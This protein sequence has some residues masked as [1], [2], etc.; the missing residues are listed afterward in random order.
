[1]QIQT[2]LKKTW[3]DFSNPKFL[4]PFLGAVVFIT[5][6]LSVGFTSGLSSDFSTQ[7]LA[8]QERELTKAFS[9][10]SF[11]W[12]AGIP[13]MVLIAIIS[14]NHIAKE[15]EEGSLRILLSKPVRR[16]EVILGKFLAIMMFTFLI[17]LVSQAFGSIILYHISGASAAALGNSIMG[18]FL[19]NAIYA[20][21]IS[22]F[23]SSL[24][25]GISV[26]TGSRL[27]TA[28][29]VV[30]IAVLLFFGFIIIRMGTGQGGVYE[31]YHLYSIDI[32]YNLGNSY[33]FINQAIGEQFSP[34]TQS[35]LST[36]SGTFDTTGASVDPLL[37]GMPTSLP[38]KGYI[39]PAV[40]FGGILA[41]SI[42][43]LT[44]TTIYFERKDIL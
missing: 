38:T 9:T 15:E 20:L 35:F 13:A 27:K 36:V 12:F 14:A 5:I 40:S 37:G 34:V 33:V 4:L 6:L 3:E 7:P 42:G 39:P 22:F 2:V 25:T 1:M 23:I 16:W 8:I 29:L 11:L 41:I 21:F 28:M 10:L 30:T 17:I 43:I 18:L 32:N 19:P 31:T 24:G 44:S 26:L